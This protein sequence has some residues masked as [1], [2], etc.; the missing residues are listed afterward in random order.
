MQIYQLNRVTDAQYEKFLRAHCANTLASGKN[1]H[2]FVN[3]PVKDNKL[4]Y[5]EVNVSMDVYIHTID[6]AARV[7]REVKKTLKAF[8]HPLTGGPEGKGWDFGRDVSASDIYALLEDIDGIDRVENLKF[9]SNGEP[10][11]EDILKIDADYLVAN[12]THTINLQVKK[13]E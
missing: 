6:V 1:M 9:I 11:A 3:G 13:G 5:V 4:L 10:T 7:D 12:G 8:L 2:I